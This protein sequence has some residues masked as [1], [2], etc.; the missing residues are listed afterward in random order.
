M[1]ILLLFFYIEA[2]S[3]QQHAAQQLVDAEASATPLIDG[4]LLEALPLWGR[5][6]RS[7][8]AKSTPTVV[9]RGSIG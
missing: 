6:T 4:D 1:L 9:G 5:V 8:R 7:G 2:S 3:G